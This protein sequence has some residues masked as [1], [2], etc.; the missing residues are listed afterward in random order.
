M[1]LYKTIVFIHTIG[2]LDNVFEKSLIA[3]R[4][5]AQGGRLRADE[6]GPFFFLPLTEPTE[7]QKALRGVR[8]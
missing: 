6:A 8:R 7:S 5:A 3:N 1:N 2:T 4:F